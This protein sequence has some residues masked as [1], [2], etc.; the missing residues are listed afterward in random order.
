VRAARGE[1]V[2][3]WLGASIAGDLTDIVSTAIAAKGVPRGS[4]QLTAAVAGG[5]ALVSAALA[6]AVDSP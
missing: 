5:A 3:P 2:R 1:P 4:P 6:Y